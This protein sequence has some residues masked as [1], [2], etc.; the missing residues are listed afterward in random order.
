MYRLY[1]LL[2]CTCAYAQTVALPPDYDTF[3]PP[4]VGNSY[5]D[6]VFGASIQR[7]SNAMATRNADRGGN[8]TWIEN[9][10]STASAFNSDNS[11]FVLLHQSYFAL[12]DGAAG[13]YLYDLPLE[14]NATSEPR[15]SRVDNHTLYYHFRNQLKSF[16]IATGGTNVVHTFD[17]YASISG[18]GEMD[19]S[20]DGDHFVFAGDGR[21]IFVY[22]IS[23]DQALP[24]LDT[25]G[26]GFD[27]IYIT[28]Q[29]NV[30]VSWGPPSGTARYQG[31]EMFDSNMN[32]L[33][34]VG[35]ANGHKHLTVDT[36]G[37]EVLIWTNSD[38]PNPLP[39]CQNGVVKIRLA[40]A[41]QTCLLQL[42]WSLAVHITAPDGNGWV[43]VDTES[44]T[45]PEPDSP[46]WVPYTN[47]LLQ[48]KLDGSGV[49]RLAHH[50]SRAVDRYNWQPKNSVSRDG[51][52]LLFSSNY[53]I[54]VTQY[55]DTYMIVPGN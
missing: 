13:A 8:L 21:F 27:S 19:I 18:N 34:Q 22:Q 12:Y 25:S 38:D 31:Q 24:A 26:H 44:P 37:D 40:D 49:V 6:P 16:D 53:G 35:H 11:R 30:L 10:Y 54:N 29:N 7:V 4:A 45:N 47:E 23:T 51:T 50:R 39:D 1:A 52:R 15:W 17:Q 43:Y 20:L 36:N 9:E 42:D 33:R 3:Q 2:V 32:F 55:A 46:K 28:P 14:V 48:V 5:I 41:S